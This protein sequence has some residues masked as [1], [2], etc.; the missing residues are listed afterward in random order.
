MNDIEPL[1]ALHQKFCELT[2]ADANDLR[3]QKHWVRYFYDLHREGF[4]S[5]EM[6]LVIRYV[7]AQNKKAKSPEYK[8][9]MVPSK[10]I[11]DLERFCEDL[12]EA[13]RLEKLKT[14]S[15]QQALNCFRGHRAPEDVQLRAVS[16]RDV[17]SRAINPPQ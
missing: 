15:K 11:G 8:R 1:R 14:T 4:T 2:G 5:E 16:L 10:V 3:F 12:A 7:Q 13:K 6:E 17:L 9:K